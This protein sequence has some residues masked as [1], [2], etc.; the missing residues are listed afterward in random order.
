VLLVIAGAVALVERTT[1]P[2]E[3]EQGG[4]RPTVTL[5]LTEALAAIDATMLRAA[6]RGPGGVG[7]LTIGPS[8][9]LVVRACCPARA[10]DPPVD[11]IQFSWTSA[12]GSLS[13]CVDNTLSRT[14][15]GRYVWVW[16]GSA[17]ITS[18]MGALR[19]YRG[20]GLRVA[21]EARVALRPFHP[22]SRAR[23]A[24]SGRPILAP[25]SC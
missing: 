19:R 9:D 11:R 1:S 18:A 23:V 25:T 13:G 2:P 20:F 21:G 10:G 14:P 12:R 3:L 5:Q 6:A 15:D 24:A 4:P 17:R 16:N 7:T 8:P 22:Q